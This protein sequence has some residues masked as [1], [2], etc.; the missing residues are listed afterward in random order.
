MD[1]GAALAAK[2]EFACLFPAART[3][4]A[5]FTLLLPTR[6]AVSVDSLSWYWGDERFVP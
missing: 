5:L 3:P 1:D 6:H 4:K 2:G